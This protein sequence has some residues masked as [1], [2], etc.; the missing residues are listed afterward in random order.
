VATPTAVRCT[1]PPP[2]TVLWS[3]AGGEQQHQ[4]QHRGEKEIEAKMNLKNQKNL[5]IP[6]FFLISFIYLFQKIFLKPAS[7]LFFPTIIYQNLKKNNED[8]ENDCF[9]FSN[10]IFMSTS[11]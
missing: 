10:V 1:T 3:P 9:S 8:N 6:F 2:P 11:Y 4:E 7:Y 5:L